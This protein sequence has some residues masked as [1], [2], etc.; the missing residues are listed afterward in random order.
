MRMFIARL[1]SRVTPVMLL[2][3][4]IATRVPRRLKRVTKE[5]FRRVQRPL[6]RRSTAHGL[7]L[8]YHRVAAGISDPWEIGVSP[9]NFRQQLD[10]LSRCA[11]VLPLAELRSRLKAGRVQRPAI[12]I[13]FDDGYVDNLH[14]ALPLLE[15]SGTPATVFI[16]TSW[17]DGGKPFW[18]DVLA[19]L[20]LQSETVPCRLHLK[21][22][23][24][25]FVWA[26]RRS[27]DG[28]SALHERAALHVALWARLQAADESGRNDA[29]DE[30]I[31]QLGAPAI[32]D[33]DARPMNVDEVRRLA[34][35]GL[36]EIGGHTMTHCSLPKRNAAE[37]FR[38]I[39]G[40]RDRCAEMTGRMPTSFAYPY[41][42]YDAGT[43]AIVARAGFARAC[44]TEQ[45][46]VWSSSDP[47]LMPR[48]NVRDWDGDTFQRRLN[49]D[50]LP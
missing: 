33:S 25:E 39:V 36:I 19:V 23:G 4:R 46:L 34:D 41:G 20:V 11:D 44:S 8:M 18:W 15:S 5:G 31:D 22:A 16:S 2:A 3:R 45:D 10:V 27:N 14:N 30:L 49:R 13:T 47:F 35:S 43:P 40:S 38:E 37:Q 28:S 12:A 29:L 48:F 7:I 42:E 17:I 1:A 32:L 24:E 26:A 50:W 6:R 21:I 9:E